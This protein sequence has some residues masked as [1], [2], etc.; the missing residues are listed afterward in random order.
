MIGST[1]ARM[2]PALLC[3]VALWASSAGAQD[4]LSVNGGDL[5][6]RASEAFIADEYRNGQLTKPDL[7]RLLGFE[8]S[9]EIDGF[10]KAH[11]V[12]EDC[13]LQDL[14]DELEGLKRLGI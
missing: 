9:H 14:E 4:R 3:S 2:L 1:D 6:R 7:R 13:T 5:S 12:Y 10:L 8:T 11:D